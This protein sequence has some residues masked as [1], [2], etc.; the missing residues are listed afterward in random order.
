MATLQQ[1][2]DRTLVLL[3]E[4]ASDTHFTPEQITGY[5]NQGQDYLAAISA[6]PEDLL[7][8]P[9]EQGVGAYTLPSDNLVFTSAY[10]GSP[11][12]A[13]DVRPLTILNKT[14]AKHMFPNWLDETA[15]TEGEPSHLWKLDDSTVFIYPRPNAASAGKTILLYYGYTPSIMVNDSDTPDIKP[16]Y[17]FLL[18][19]Y[20]CRMAYYALTN[21]VMAKEMFGAFMADFN[22]VKGT[23]DKEAEETFAFKWGIKE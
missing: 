22:A 14:I 16:N 9:V 15:A 13:N 8:V 10:F 23:V 19:L 7:T 5:L 20:A 11:T 2:K 1:L 3:R 12:E 21:P 6:P 17:H 18:P 4:T